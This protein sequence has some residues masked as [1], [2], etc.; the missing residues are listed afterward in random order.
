MS[1][2]LNWITTGL[3]PWQ[4]KTARY[5]KSTVG[6]QAA[7]QVFHIGTFKPYSVLTKQPKSGL[8]HYFALFDNQDH[9]R[10][11]IKNKK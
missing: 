7:D 5:L 8:K 6:S 1:I 11:S 10:A 3:F 4:M 9:E 2:R